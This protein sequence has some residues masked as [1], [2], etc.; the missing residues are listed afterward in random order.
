VEITWGDQPDTSVL[1]QR[2][3]QTL[4][5]GPSTATALTTSLGADPVELARALDELVRGRLVARSSGAA[6]ETFA[7]TPAGMTSAAL[8]NSVASAIGPDGHLDMAAVGRDV[9]SLWQ[10]AQEARS[11]ELAHSQAGTLADDADRERTVTLLE[12]HYSRG[13]FDLAQL[14]R[15][16]AA[17]LAARTHG[18]LAGLTRDLA[19]P[20]QA[21]SSVVR[22]VRTVSTVA[23]VARAVILVGFAV[24]IVVTVVLPLLR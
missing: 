21:E 19:A 13:T 17:A 15:R 18:D 14:E 12:D 3:V 7:L 10:A 5:A 2:V 20:A 1:Q 4:S 16:T 22:A 11:A 23:K 24:L 6:A 9:G 8:Q